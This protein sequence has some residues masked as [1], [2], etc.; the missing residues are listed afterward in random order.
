LNVVI[1]Q[2]ATILELFACENEAL[3]VRGD[4]VLKQKILSRKDQQRD[5]R[6]NPPLLVLDFGLDIVN[7]ITRF[8]L[9]RDLLAWVSRQRVCDREMKTNWFCP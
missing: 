8:H 2:R 5:R 9:E 4:A 6:M 7:G 1:A 3:L